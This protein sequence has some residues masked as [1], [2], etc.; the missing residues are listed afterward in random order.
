MIMVYNAD[1]DFL[2]GPDLVI[3]ARAAGTVSGPT[4]VSTRPPPHLRITVE[5][6]HS[7]A[8]PFAATM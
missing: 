2:Y 8:G 3:A 7:L 1:D 5:V 6:P 4:K